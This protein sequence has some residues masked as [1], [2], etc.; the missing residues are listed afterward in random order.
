ML[1]DTHT[2]VVNQGK[3]SFPYAEEFEW[4]E[5]QVAFLV[6]LAVSN[7]DMEVET[8]MN[9][10]NFGVNEIVEGIVFSKAAYIESE[11][12]YFIVTEDMMTH[13]IVTYSRWD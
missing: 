11:A 13:I 5:G 1:Y 2:M 6:N 4:K 7:S 12:G 10:R 9:F 8:P 3:F